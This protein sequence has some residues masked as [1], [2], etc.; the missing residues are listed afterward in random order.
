MTYPTDS[1]AIASECCGCGCVC[2]ASLYDGTLLLTVVV[3]G[4]T[5]GP[6]TLFGPVAYYNGSG[7]VFTPFP[8]GFVGDGT[9]AG[10]FYTFSLFQ[11]GAPCTWIFETNCSLGHSLRDSGGTSSSGSCTLF[12]MT[13]TTTAADCIH[14]WSVTISLPPMM[15]LV[16]PE[17]SPSPIGPGVKE[18]AVSKGCGCGKLTREELLQKLIENGF[19]ISRQRRHEQARRRRL[20]SNNYN[21]SR[22][23]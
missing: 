8:C 15:A 16:E 23:G 6:F 3:S 7:G 13:A 2:C 20:A 17:P 12:P 11:S 19:P 18:K 1:F 21:A 10:T 5:Y 9:I 22:P 14:G 4:V